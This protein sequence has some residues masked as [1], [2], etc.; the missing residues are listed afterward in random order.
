MIMMAWEVDDADG[1]DYS[2]DEYVDRYGDQK[3]SPLSMDLT[4]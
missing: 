4:I 1:V 2:G 3:S